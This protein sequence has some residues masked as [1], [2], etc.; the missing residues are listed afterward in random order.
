M[1][2]DGTQH[3]PQRSQQ[4]KLEC[5]RYWHPSHGIDRV[6]QDGMLAGVLW[7]RRVE[8]VATKPVGHH[9]EDLPRE[10]RQA[11]SSA[12]LQ[13][14]FRGAPRG[15]CCSFRGAAAMR[16]SNALAPNL[17]RRVPLCGVT[18]APARALAPG[19]SVTGLSSRAASR[20]PQRMQT[21]VLSF[22]EPY[23]H[24][25]SGQREPRLGTAMPSPVRHC[26]ST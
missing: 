14:H 22:N 3:R 24:P 10:E 23:C 2:R 6:W 8:E 16:R 13:F 17:V 21:A 20:S 26:R 25:I 18:Q 15:R 9:H 12:R 19:C 5:R 4:R 7:P 1:H 11:G